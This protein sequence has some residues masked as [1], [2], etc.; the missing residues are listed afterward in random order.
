M[1]SHGKEIIR[2]VCVRTTIRGWPPSHAATGG[3]KRW[4]C[5]F[6]AK[7]PLLRAPRK[8]TMGCDPSTHIFSCALCHES[9]FHRIFILTEKKTVLHPKVTVA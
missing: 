9:S 1:L 7:N 8:C 5:S 4:R 6:L 2:N 3:R